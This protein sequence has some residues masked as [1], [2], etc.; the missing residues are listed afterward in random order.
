MS[1]PAGCCWPTASLNFPYHSAPKSARPVDAFVAESPAVYDFEVNPGWHQ[2]TFFNHD[3][4]HPKRAGINLSGPRVE[5]SLG[6]DPQREYHLYDFWNQRYA[7]KVAGDS[8]VEQDLRPG[9]ARMIS[10]RECLTRPQVISTDRHVM[11]GYLDLLRVDWD[12]RRRV[13]TGVSRIIG[14]DRYT[15]TLALNGQSP[16][17]VECKDK[18]I[19]AKLSSVKEDIAGFTLEGPD[20]GTIEWSVAFG[21]E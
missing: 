9:E 11:Q 3:K 18:N 10:V 13:L 14:G 1:P 16:R 4:E 7:G 6:L 19:T 17:K 20:N 12:E 8:R 21:A 2:V 15:V 5:G